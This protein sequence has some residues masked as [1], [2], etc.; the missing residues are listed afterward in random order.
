LSEPV[1]IYG[2]PDLSADLFHAVPVSIID[3]FLYLEAGDKRAA[4][5]SVLDAAKVRDLGIEILD[6]YVLGRDELLQQGLPPHEIDNEVSLRACRTAGITSA[7]VPPEFPLSLADHLRAAGVTLTVDADRFVRR[8][9]TKTG[10]QLEGIRRAQKAADAAMARAAELIHRLD[11]GLTAEAVRAQMQAICEEHGCEL[12][13][14]VIVAHG[15]QAADGHEPGHGEIAAGE[16]VVVDIWPRDKVS[17]CWADM[18]RTFV[19]G[20]GEAPQELT[21]YWE[22]TRESLDRIYPMVR[23]GADCREIYEASCQPYVDAGLPTQLTKEPG[24]VLNE[25]Y[26]HGLGHGVGLE[27]HERPNLGRT[28]DTLVAGDVITLEPGCYRPG[29]GGVRLEDLVV[30]TEDGCETLTDFPYEM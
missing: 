12:P 5:V 28:A 22:L 2:A 6:P 7:A 23:A 10:H 11:A 18:T 1:L 19:A 13:D 29:F 21:R 16:P 20:G 26:F 3:P 8:R 27:V 15:G 30:V 4:T 24:T 14:D 17:R 9:R 25:G